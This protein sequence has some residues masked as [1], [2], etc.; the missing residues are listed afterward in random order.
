MNGFC[1]VYESGI[2]NDKTYFIVMNKLGKSLKD[3]ASEHKK[4]FSLRTICLIGAQMIERL[5]DF[6]SL[7]M[8]H[9]DIKP[10]NVLLGSNNPRDRDHN[11]L[12]LIDY[13]L[14]QFYINEEGE[15]RPIGRAKRFVG[16]IGFASKNA[17]A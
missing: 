8:V 13:G 7:G 5:E 16:N 6:H 10:D 4:T 12:Y 17:F 1:K 15:H 11:V 2:L 3:I 14:S 9:A